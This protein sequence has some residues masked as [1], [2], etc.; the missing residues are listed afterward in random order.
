MTNATTP[1]K[2][3]E[4]PFTKEFHNVLES[5]FSRAMK[6]AVRRKRLP[7]I[8]PISEINNN[9]TSLVMGA[10]TT[11]QIGELLINNISPL[12]NGGVKISGTLTPFGDGARL[13]IEAVNNG[14]LTDSITNLYG[15]WGQEDHKFVTVLGLESSLAK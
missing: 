15:L 3:F 1:L 10:L 5:S 14:T 7:I 9:N 2:T 12:E 13:F 8:A 11:C 4:V 6:K